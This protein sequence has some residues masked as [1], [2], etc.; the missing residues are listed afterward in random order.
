MILLDLSQHRCEETEN[1]KAAQPGRRPHRCMHLYVEFD[2]HGTK[3]WF[4][5]L[6]HWRCMSCRA[7][8]NPGSMEHEVVSVPMSRPDDAVTAPS[9]V[10]MTRPRDNEGRFARSDSGSDVARCACVQASRPPQLVLRSRTTCLTCPYSTRRSRSRRG[11]QETASM[12]RGYISKPFKPS[13]SVLL[14]PS[15]PRCTEKEVNGHFSDARRWG[16]SRKTGS[17][18]R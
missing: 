17:W 3:G 9:R 4:P 7:M 14:A 2:R 16:R 8:L 11:K 5:G 13:K 10:R 1:V 15:C 6:L 18:I 12:K